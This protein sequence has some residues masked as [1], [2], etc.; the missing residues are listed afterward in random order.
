MNPAECEAMSKSN[1]VGR[2]NP[3]YIDKTLEMKYGEG[4]GK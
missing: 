4:P 1:G 3:R 2:D